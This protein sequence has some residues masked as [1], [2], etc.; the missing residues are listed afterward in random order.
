MRHRVALLNDRGDKENINSTRE[1]A[2]K[3]RKD[4]QTKTKRVKERT[5]YRKIQ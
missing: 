5:L 3:T 2:Q 1:E 4:K